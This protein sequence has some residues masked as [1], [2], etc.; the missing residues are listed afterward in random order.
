MDD[1]S[2]HSKASQETFIS[3]LSLEPTP[4]E[5]PPDA[6]KELPKSQQPATTASTAT[7]LGLSG[8]GHGAIYFCMCLC[9]SFPLFECLSRTMVTG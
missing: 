7:S 3:L 6:E 2:L 5:N 1:K 4:M 8:S 9:H